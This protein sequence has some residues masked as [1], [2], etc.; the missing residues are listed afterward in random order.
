MCYEITTG[1]VFTKSA[2]HA[3]VNRDVCVFITAVPITKVFAW[4]GGG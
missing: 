2:H 1:L 3:L 4:G